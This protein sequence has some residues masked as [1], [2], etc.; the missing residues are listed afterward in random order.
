MYQGKS[1][2]VHFYKN[3]GWFQTFRS[4]EHMIYGIKM[5]RNINSM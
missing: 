3:R 2:N 1:G 4:L 5:H